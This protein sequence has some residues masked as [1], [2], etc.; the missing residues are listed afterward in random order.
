MPSISSASSARSLAVRRA[1]CPKSSGAITSPARMNMFPG[2][3][4][5]WKRPNS[6]T[7]LRMKSAPRS[8]TRT[9]SSPAARS[10]SAESGLTPSM[11]SIVSTPSAQSASW[12]AAR[13]RSARRRSC[14]RMPGDCPL[15][16]KIRLAIDRLGEFPRQPV[17]IDRLL[18][19]QR[20]GQGGERPSRISQSVRMAS[21]TPGRRTLTAT[22]SPN[23]VRARWTC[24]MLAAASG[25]GWNS[26]NSSSSGRPSCDWTSARI[27]ANSTGATCS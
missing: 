13:G 5:V 19:A 27:A 26:A 11:Y 2:C 3:G 18:D 10:A 14:V 21:T 7:C 4:S 22:A 8:A 24:A 6:K 15:N 1:T 23:S 12:R 25:A 17:R 9:G 16:G 20:R